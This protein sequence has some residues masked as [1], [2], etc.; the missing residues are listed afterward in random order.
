MR[1]DDDRVEAIRACDR[2][3]FVALV[4]Q[5]VY[6]IHDVALSIV[7]SPAAAV[8]VSREAVES[9]WDRHH[10]LSAGFLS[11]RPG[12]ATGAPSTSSLNFVAGDIVPDA[13]QVGLP[14][15]GANAGKI[16]IT[17]DAYGVN[18]AE[19]AYTVVG[20]ATGTS[21]ITGTAL[22]QTT[23]VNSELTVRNP[24]GNSTALTI[25]PLAGGTRAVAATLLIELV[26]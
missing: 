4:E 16:D 13:V 25:T 22:V 11:I 15:T 2:G 7:G 23:S 21:Q 19:L 3:A 5:W 12:D 6:R 26:R 8:E 9:L 18:G 24:A 17:F 14:T 1:V 20:R 10:D